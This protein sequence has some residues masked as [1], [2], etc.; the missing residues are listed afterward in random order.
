MAVQIHS[1][2]KVGN[3]WVGGHYLKSVSFSGCCLSSSLPGYWTT[4]ANTQKCNDY[5]YFGRWSKGWFCFAETV[6]N[7]GNIGDVSQAITSIRYKLS[8]MTVTC[9]VIIV[10]CFLTLVRTHWHKPTCD[11]EIRAHHSTEQSLPAERS[12]QIQVSGHAV[13]FG[14][15][16]VH[17]V[18]APK[19]SSKVQK[20]I[21]NEMQLG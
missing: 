10:T 19:K 16:E 7:Q 13:S 11:L 2:S 8:H 18:L 20:I 15:T 6:A 21:Q 14:G 5:C 3:I 12:R 17:C 4:F 9:V 1:G